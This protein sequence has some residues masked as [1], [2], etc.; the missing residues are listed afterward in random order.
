MRHRLFTI[1]AGLLVGGSMAVAGCD[2]EK[3]QDGELPEVEVKAGQLPK[4]D[5]D[6]AEVEVGTQETKVKVPDVDVKM[7]ETTIKVP[8]VDVKMPDDEADRD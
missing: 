4:Y 6:V 3:T 5:V 8:D 2:L 7:K 1:M